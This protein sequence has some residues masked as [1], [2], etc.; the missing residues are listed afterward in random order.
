M[1]MTFANVEKFTKMDPKVLNAIKGTGASTDAQLT[2]YYDYVSSLADFYDNIKDNKAAINSASIQNEAI[3][4]FIEAE[5]NKMKDEKNKKIR[6]IKNAQYEFRRYENQKQLFK[7]L[8]YA[9]LVILAIIFAQRSKF[10]PQ[11]ISTI[12]IMLV[13]AYFV[14]TLINTIIT[15]RGRYNFDFDVLHK[16]HQK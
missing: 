13:G 8:S 10:I 1:Y 14:I 12:L 16:A 6:L 15:N 9:T 2:S 4:E 11:Y 5:E 3:Q 7:K